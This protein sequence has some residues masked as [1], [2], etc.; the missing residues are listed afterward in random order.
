MSTVYV[1]TS[2]VRLNATKMTVYDQKKKSQS[3][4]MKNAKFYRYGLFSVRIRYQRG[5]KKDQQ[6]KMF[7][8]KTFSGKRYQRTSKRLLLRVSMDF[9]QVEKMLQAYRS[10]FPET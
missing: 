7:F 4:F 8:R 9:Q 10:T 3:L 1:Q 2:A 6:G 5:L